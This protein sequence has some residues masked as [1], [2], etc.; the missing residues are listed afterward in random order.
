MGVKIQ[1]IDPNI[2]PLDT[3]EIWRSSTKAGAPVKIGDVPGS[4]HE[5]QDDTAPR[6]KVSWYSLKSVLGTGSAM[7]KP[8]AVGNFPDTGPGPADIMRGDWE[9]GIF[10]EVDANLIP[11]YGEIKDAVG[12]IAFSAS[13]TKFYKWIINGRIVF[14]PWVPY[15]NTFGTQQNQGALI[16][17]P[18]GKTN[19]DGPVILER[20]GRAYC[21]RPPY[22][23][24][25]VTTAVT[26]SVPSNGDETLP[27][28]ELGAMMGSIVGI[29]T[30]LKF[31]PQKWGDVA[32][33]NYANYIFTNTFVNVN[34]L[35]M[36]CTILSAP[37]LVASSSISTTRGFWP[38]YELLLT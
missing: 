29:D 22:A 14:I 36:V 38:V 26:T 20:E 33:P 3:V 28:T 12:G 16:Q 25:N 32:N 31:T 8:F 24:N 5:F 35:T 10:G 19:E 23:T 11:S 7:S 37:G 6:N 15:S 17:I 21:V 34:G 18:V 30:A 27:L 13:P 2:D 9:F 1:W 4:I